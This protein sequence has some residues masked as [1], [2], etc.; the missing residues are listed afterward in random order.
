MS[1]RGASPIAAG[2]LLAHES[3]RVRELNNT[4]AASPLVLSVAVARA[5]VRVRGGGGIAGREQRVLVDGLGVARHGPSRPRR[6]QRHE[7]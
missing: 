7:G 5:P 4:A 2:S 3:H 1:P 6:L